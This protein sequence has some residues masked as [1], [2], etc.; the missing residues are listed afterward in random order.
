[1]QIDFIGAV[2][3]LIAELIG[4]GKI[5]TAKYFELLAKQIV[6]ASDS[7]QLLE[8]LDQLLSGASIIQYANFTH[9]E[10]LLYEALYKAAM[11]LKNKET[12]G[13]KGNYRGQVYIPHP[14][15]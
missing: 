2:N 14:T 11:K 7:K 5:D 4:S 3:N 8:L 10:E 9:K 15:R 12:I 1:M 6:G 13:V